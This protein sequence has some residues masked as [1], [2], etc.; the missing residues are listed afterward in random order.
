[1]D[2]SSL[3][4]KIKS[5]QI[6]K[7][8]IFTGDE[9]KVQD[10]YIQQI[11]KVTGKEVKYVDSIVD[12]YSKLKSRSF[13]SKPV[14]YK[15]RD[16]KELMTN[17]KLQQN[18]ESVLAD[19][20]LIHTLTSVDKRTKYYKTYK[21]TIVEFKA[22][23]D[24][25]LKRYIKREIDLSDRNCQI[26]IDVCEHDYGRI[27][28]EIDK[29]K[30]YDNINGRDKKSAADKAFEQLLKDGTIYEPPYDAIFDLVDAILDRKV[31]L[32]F[33]LMQ[34]SY[35][36]GEATMVM[37]SVLYNNAKAVLQVQSYDGSNLSK[38]TGLTG[39]QIKNAKKHVGKYSDRELERMLRLIYKVSN[40]I[41]TGKMEDAF[42]MQYLL[43]H[44][45]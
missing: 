33:D 12:V 28:L 17:E 5:R 27:L 25:I 14:I 39:W 31:N 22:L 41:K 34:Q 7:Y 21:D 9:W 37:L 3:K 30:R 20:M 24:A 23:T 29:I 1:M 42:A 2:V 6:P 8:L 18:I 45:V 13:I 26:L 43:V 16:D 36:V 11:S 19:N 15:V 4:A 35:D 44:I 32:T 40:G 38:A 10:I